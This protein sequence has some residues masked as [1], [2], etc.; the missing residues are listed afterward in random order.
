MVPSFFTNSLLIFSSH[1]RLIANFNYKK[2]GILKE[3][4]KQ[5][6]S[7][8]KLAKGTY[9]VHDHSENPGPMDWD[10]TP[11]TG[12]VI[13]SSNQHWNA[14]QR[15][16]GWDQRSRVMRHYQGPG[17]CDH[18]IM[19]N[20]QD[21]GKRRPQ[22]LGSKC[23]NSVPSGRRREAAVL[24]PSLHT[25]CIQWRMEIQYVWVSLFQELYD[26]WKSVVSSPS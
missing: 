13:K 21:P 15:W 19:D 14:S 10:P 11:M 22:I 6:C 4:K 16:H 9:W 5:T 2:R 7:A 17:L 25:P 18:E 26:L 24:N 3:S 20:F 8:R 23:W 1:V 12:L